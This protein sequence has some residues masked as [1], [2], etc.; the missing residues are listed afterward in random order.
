[1]ADIQFT[2]PKSHFPGKP[3][4]VEVQCSGENGQCGKQ[5]GRLIVIQEPDDS[6]HLIFT[7]D[8]S[9][10]QVAYEH[11]FGAKVGL[12]FAGSASFPVLCVDAG[13]NELITGES[14]GEQHVWTGGNR[15]TAV[16]QSAA[17]AGNPFPFQTLR[18]PFAEFVRSNTTQIVSWAAGNFD[19]RA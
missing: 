17:G 9:A 4:A 2:G 10:W 3:V 5:L 19:E 6:V 13:H 12:G 1:M 11:R 8:E 16:G 14:T 7:T 15:L 18:E